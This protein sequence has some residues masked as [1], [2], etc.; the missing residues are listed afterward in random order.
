MWGRKGLREAGQGAEIK[1]EAAGSA[2]RVE[3]KARGGDGRGSRRG[4]RVGGE[5]DINGISHKCS[6][7]VRAYTLTCFLGS[8]HVL[9]SP[10]HYF[11][12]HSPQAVHR[13]RC[14]KP[15]SR[16]QKGTILSFKGKAKPQRK[17]KTQI[18]F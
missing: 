12:D 16:Q 13:M 10:S 4:Q 7:H 18:K 9:Q 17:L 8:D 15:S 5:G 14:I 11:H 3:G 6:V 1:A 2:G